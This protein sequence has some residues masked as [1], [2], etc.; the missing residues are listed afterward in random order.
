MAKPVE[1]KH[2]NYVRIYGNDVKAN[3]AIVYG[4][5]NIK[6]VSF[7]MA[8]AMCHVLGFDKKK[9]ISE[10]TEKEIEKIE[11]FITNPKK[12][13]IPEW[14]L[15]QR[16]DMDTGENKHYF[17]KDIDFNVLQTKRRLYKIKTY[18][19]LRLR[20]G[21]TVR[22]QRTG[23]NFRRNKTITSMKSKSGAKRNA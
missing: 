20:L 13:G 15:N 10:L 11:A 5:R 2:E 16:K 8:N 4:L 1:K 22:G 12:E 7:M 23:S 17:G 3:M 9:K 21:L 6:G 18:R 14:M 19:G